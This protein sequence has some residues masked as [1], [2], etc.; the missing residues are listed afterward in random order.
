VTNNKEIFEKVF[1]SFSRSLF[2]SSDKF[3]IRKLK[4]K[5]Q[6]KNIFCVFFFQYETLREEEFHGWK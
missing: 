5:K 2:F 1:F 3:L 4:K 6:E